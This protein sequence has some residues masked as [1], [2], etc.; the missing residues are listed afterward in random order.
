MIL[1]A[2]G[3]NKA[4]EDISSSSLQEVTVNNVT[5]R[6]INAHTEA[7]GYRIEVCYTLPDQ[8]DWL[9]TY[10]NLASDTVLVTADMKVAPSEEGTMYWKYD[11]RG[12]ATQRCQYLF[13]SARLPSQTNI[14]TLRIGKLY[15][16]KP[17]QS[18]HCLEISEKMA[19]RGVMA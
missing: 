18:D 11:Q 16:R 3:K 6:L 17:T 4:T 9:L 8:R 7:S 1:N 19:E 14:L 13:F 12:I 10:P 15:A 5:M 2:R